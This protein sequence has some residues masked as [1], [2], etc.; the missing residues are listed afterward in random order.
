M[1]EALRTVHSATAVTSGRSVSNRP[2][3]G[4][5]SHYAKLD[6]TLTTNPIIV[7]TKRNE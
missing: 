2:R 7:A 3:G 4:P 6:S 5:F 1:A